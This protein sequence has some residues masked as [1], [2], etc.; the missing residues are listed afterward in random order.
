MNTI[1]WFSGVLMMSAEWQLEIIRIR[2]TRKE[3]F[4]LPFF[5]TESRN[6]KLHSTYCLGFILLSYLMILFVIGF[7]LSWVG[8]VLFLVGF[9]QL[10]E[11][12]FRTVM[13]KPYETPFFTLATE[14]IKMDKGSKKLHRLKHVSF[15]GDVYL[16]MIFVA[17]VATFL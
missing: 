2:A 3:L 12:Q 6:Y 16:L 17:F 9:W 4:S 8:V 1:F 10:A 7:G 5:F 11:I 14:E 13:G 15:W